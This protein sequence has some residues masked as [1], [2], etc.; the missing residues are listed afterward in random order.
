MMTT[1]IYFM[2]P[3][4]SL[5]DC[6]DLM[7][8]KR[9]RHLPVIENKQL[10]GLVSIGDI[11]NRIITEQKSKIENLENYIIGSDYGATIRMPS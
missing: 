3:D 10:R 1:T 7:T 2:K 8:K 11:V 4:N 6:L 9:T 5:W